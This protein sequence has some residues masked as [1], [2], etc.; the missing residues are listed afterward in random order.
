M[1]EGAVISKD[2]KRIFP[3]VGEIIDGNQGKNRARN[4]ALRNSSLDRKLG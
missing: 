2:I 4:I 1:A 3:R